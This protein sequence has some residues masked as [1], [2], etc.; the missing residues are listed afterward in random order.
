MA[1]TKE[2]RDNM[3]QCVRDHRLFCQAA[4][5]QQHVLYFASVSE[6]VAARAAR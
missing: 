3:Q 4:I 6:N 5:H 1:S 2:D